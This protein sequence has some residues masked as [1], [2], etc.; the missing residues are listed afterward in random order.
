MVEI[1]CSLLSLTEA[2]QAPLEGRVVNLCLIVDEIE[3]IVEYSRTYLRIGSDDYKKVWY[4][5]STSPDA[6]KW[7]NVVSYSSA[8]LFQL[9]RS[10]VSTLKII[11]NERRMSLGSSTL[12]DLLVVNAEG[13]TL[14][15]FSA[16]SAVNLWWSDSFSGRRVNQKPRKEYRKSKQSSALAASDSGEESET[17][18][19]LDSWD[20]WF[21]DVD[22]SGD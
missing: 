3:D 9:Q 22:I 5:L 11:K 1:K 15:N 16:D 19:A 4:Q 10:N 13:P 17:E 12:S 7:P 21:D 18:L 8:Y 6:V 2:F 14:A 20:G